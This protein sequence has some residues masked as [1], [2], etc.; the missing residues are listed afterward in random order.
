MYSADIVRN[1]LNLYF[2][3]CFSSLAAPNYV[4]MFFII[5]LF[6]IFFYFLAFQN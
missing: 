4:K 6:M 5:I 3:I 2:I 1:C